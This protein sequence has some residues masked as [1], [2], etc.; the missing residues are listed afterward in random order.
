MD[1]DQLTPQLTPQLVAGYA[2]DSIASRGFAK[3]TLMDRTGAVCVRGALNEVLTGDP[4]SGPTT[5]KLLVLRGEIEDLILQFA[6]TG[7]ATV[8]IWN[9][10]DGI[11][12]EDVLLV[13]RAV[14][15]T[16]PET[17]SETNDEQRELVTA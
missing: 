9:D 2:A 16:G 4:M 15:A 5:S 10:E 1:V 8:P 14:A 11:T 3:K 13:L 12:I 17:I 7:S 6:G